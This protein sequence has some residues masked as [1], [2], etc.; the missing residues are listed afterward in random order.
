ME[1]SQRKVGDR[2]NEIVKQHPPQVVQVDQAVT[3]HNAIS[4]LHSLSEIRDNHSVFN[5]TDNYMDK[6][7]L[8]DQ[9][10]G[11]FQILQ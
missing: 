8:T 4:Q 1:A 3:Y 7:I 9:S 5:D 10:F 6:T 11:N 2:Y